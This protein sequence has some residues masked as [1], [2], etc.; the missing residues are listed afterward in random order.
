DRGEAFAPQKR[1]CP[2]PVGRFSR[3]PFAK[4]VLEAAFFPGVSLQKQRNPE[5]R[6]IDFIKLHSNTS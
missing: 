3:T 1:E 5:K 6:T 4:G 2:T